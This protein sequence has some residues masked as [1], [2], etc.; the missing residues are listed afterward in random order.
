MRSAGRKKNTNMSR[1]IKALLVL[2]ILGGGL[3]S[4]GIPAGI[5]RPTDN[6]LNALIDKITGRISSYPE[7]KYWNASVTSVLT[8]MEKTW[9]PKK[10][11]RVF[12]TVR[13][14]DKERSEEILRAEETENGVVKDV[15]AKLVKEAEE[16]R[17]KAKKS[18][19]EAGETRGDED[20]ER[21]RRSLD[22]DDLLPFSEIN[23]PQ[24]AFTRLEDGLLDG[25]P[26]YVLQSQAKIKSE[27][28]WE[29]R[30]FIGQDGHDVLKVALTL[31]KNPKFVKEF[32]VE[33]EFQVLTS[34]HFVVKRSRTKVDAG[35]VLKHVRMVIEEEYTD[36][37]IT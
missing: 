31:S 33:V 32:T 8:E 25:R 15:T 37:E 17:R 36:Y 30:Y 16:G 5:G 7:L 28:L 24:Y 29:G 3:G 26:V 23:R 34:G 9:K 2:M 11:T 14:A 35:M 21:G 20:Q 1:A 4:A 13:I 6:D 10:V 27:R 18:D 19:K 22:S 12:K